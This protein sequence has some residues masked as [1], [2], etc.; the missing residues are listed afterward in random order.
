MNVD[1][2]NWVT[3]NRKGRI[4]VSIRSV[5]LRLIVHEVGLTSHSFSVRLIVH[6]VGLASQSVSLIVHEVGLAI[7]Y[8]WNPVGTIGVI[9]NLTYNTRVSSFW[10]PRV[11]YAPVIITGLFQGYIDN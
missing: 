2:R 8:G 4:G 1:N 9:S 11:F 5:S 6:E 3:G 7:P 10:A